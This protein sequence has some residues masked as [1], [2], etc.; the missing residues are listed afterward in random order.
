[1]E[2]LR[3]WLFVPGHQ[4]RMI[5]K[6]LDLRVDSVVLDLEDGVAATSRDAARELIRAATRA[7]RDGPAVFVRV[8]DVHHRELANDLSVGFGAGIDGIVLPK[9]Q[10]ADDV[11]GFDQLLGAREVGLGLRLG[12]LSVVAMIESAR[13]LVHLAEIAASS[14]RLVGLMFGAE[15]FA[16][17]LGLWAARQPQ[18]SDHL[19]ARS[20]LAI[21]AASQGL[22]A[23]DRVCTILGATEALSLD[24]RQ[25]RDLG[26]SG[27]ALIHPGQIPAVHEAFTPSPDELQFARRVVA[28]FE[29]AGTNDPGAIAVEGQM[30]DRPVAERARQMLAAWSRWNS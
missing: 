25:A 14:P 28:A 16:L 27:K 4:Q 7:K 11:R 18:A 26:F 29:A 22:Q 15:D 9:V 19:Y 24:A 21:A 3:S 5:D 1:M 23:I 20:S 12:S 2:L 6:A 8:H 30:V 13:G 10:S 17:D